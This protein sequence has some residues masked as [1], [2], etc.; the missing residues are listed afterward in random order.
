MRWRARGAEGGP[1]ITRGGYL[2]FA[3]VERYVCVDADVDGAATATARRVDG[4]EA[5]ERGMGDVHA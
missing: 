5:T 4:R 2:V 3:V 1:R